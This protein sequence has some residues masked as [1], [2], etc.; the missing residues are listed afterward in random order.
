[1]IK[2]YTVNQLSLENYRLSSKIVT[3]WNIETSVDQIRSSLIS[4]TR[5]PLLFTA[6]HSFKLTPRL[7]IHSRVNRI[8]LDRLLFPKRLLDIFAV[9]PNVDEQFA[10]GYTKGALAERNMLLNHVGGRHVDVSTPRAQLRAQAF[11][12]LVSRFFLLRIDDRELMLP[13]SR[14]YAWDKISVKYHIHLHAREALII[15]KH[16]QQLI[17]R[18]LQVMLLELLEH[19]PRA[20]H[21]VSIDQQN[22]VAPIHALDAPALPHDFIHKHACCNRGIQ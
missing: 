7:Q 16:V 1:M 18:I 15:R 17:P 5:F 12:A 14:P 19:W 20:D 21:I 4:P 8:A 2:P 3:L 13:V 9:L 6:S 10:R 11:N 22:V